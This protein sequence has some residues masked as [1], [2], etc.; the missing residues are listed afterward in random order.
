MNV[1]CGWSFNSVFDTSSCSNY[2]FSISYQTILY[3][4][5]N[6]MFVGVLKYSCN[7]S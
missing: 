7:P 4:S 5:D 1:D 2:L 3:L 6:I